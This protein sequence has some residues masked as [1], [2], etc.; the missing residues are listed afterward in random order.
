MSRYI[1]PHFTA[2]ELECKCGCGLLPHE[3][4]VARLEG[5]REAVGSP[6]VILSGARCQAHNSRVAATGTHGPHIPRATNPECGAVDFLTWGVAC[7]NFLHMGKERG[8]LGYGLAQSGPPNRRWMHMDNW[9]P[10]VLPR[11]AI[12]TYGGGGSGE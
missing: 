9:P 4:F 10:G 8:W 11:P 12:W 3:E 6:M 7:L 2:R 1:S 5:L